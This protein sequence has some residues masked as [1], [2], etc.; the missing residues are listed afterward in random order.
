MEKILHLTGDTLGEEIV[1]A[2]DTY[3]DRLPN[4]RAV[5]RLGRII[6]N[7]GNSDTESI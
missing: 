5:A 6:I 1:I 4:G 7:A 3:R 2:R